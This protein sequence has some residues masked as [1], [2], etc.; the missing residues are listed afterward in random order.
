[1]YVFVYYPAIK[2]GAA[3]MHASNKKKL[4]F[5]LDMGIW[6]KLSAFRSN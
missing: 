3:M 2:L 1:M 4:G 5:Y 6:M